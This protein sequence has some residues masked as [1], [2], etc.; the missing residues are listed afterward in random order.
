M[1]R[2]QLK[3]LLALNF[4]LL[5]VLTFVSMPGA[6]AQPD[7]A[8]SRGQYTMVNAKIQGISE[9]GLYVVDSA[10][11]ELL[12][13]RWDNSRKT[14]KGIGYRDLVADALRASSTTPTGR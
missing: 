13:L 5:G 6:S 11:Q 2:R 3:P 9:S 4:I 14:I 7:R 12:V 8:R 1:N 10:N